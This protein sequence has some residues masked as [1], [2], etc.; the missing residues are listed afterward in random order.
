[1]PCLTLASSPSRA[2]RTDESAKKGKKQRI[3]ICPDADP[4]NADW[5]PIVRTWRLTGYCLPKW[6]SLWLCRVSPW[7]E[8][9]AKRTFKL[10][11]G[12]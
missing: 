1:M 4:T 7:E 6:A 5:I 3:V 9:C 11:L 10:L 8:K 12:A 2:R